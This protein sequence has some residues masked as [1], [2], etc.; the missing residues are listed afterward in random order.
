MINPVAV[1]IKASLIPPVTSWA[2]TPEAPS[3]IKEKELIS[4]KTVP[5][6]PSKGETV[7]I[8]ENKLL[9]FP[10]SDWIDLIDISKANLIS[11]LLPPSKSVSYTHLTLPTKA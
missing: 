3:L 11:I 1:E 5:R 7:I 10:S 4:P 9:N 2:F 8:V 6:S